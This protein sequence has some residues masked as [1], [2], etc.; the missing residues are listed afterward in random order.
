MRYF[1]VLLNMAITLDE[2]QKVYLRIFFEIS[3]TQRLHFFNDLKLS[4]FVYY[5]VA[6]EDTSTKQLIDYPDARLSDQEQLLEYHEREGNSLLVKFPTENRFLT[7]DNERGL[8]SEH[9]SDAMYEYL[10]S[11]L[12]PRKPAI[13]GL[14][15]IRRN[16]NFD[17]E[18]VSQ[19]GE[20]VGV[21][22]LVFASAWPFFKALMDSN[23]QETAEKR[24]LLPYPLAWIEPVASYLYEEPLEMSFE[25]AL[26]VLVVSNVYDLPGLGEIAQKRILKEPLNVVKAALGWKRAFEAQCEDV[27]MYMAKWLR[28]SVDEFYKSKEWKEFSDEEVGQFEEDVRE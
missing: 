25:Q 2:I 15:K 27:R 23:M 13:R 8:N 20:T 17:F 7:P 6:L 18:I 4:S 10:K 11:S 1:I 24:L 14:G 12:G 5:A 21:H 3:P 19:E 9:V 16:G 28:E 22:T 26:G